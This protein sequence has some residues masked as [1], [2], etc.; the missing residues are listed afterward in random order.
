MDIISEEMKSYMQGKNIL[1]ASGYI[2]IRV[3]GELLASSWGIK[4]GSPFSHPLN[5]I[6][7]LNK[8]E[9]NKECL[10][11]FLK[12]L[13][14]ESVYY[15]EK[16]YDFIFDEDIIYKAIK[17]DKKN[18]VIDSCLYLY[19][20]YSRVERFFDTITIQ[21]LHRD[22]S[23]WGGGRDDKFTVNSSDEE[24]IVEYLYNLINN[25]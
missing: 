23:A 18:K 16:G 4:E 10:K 3:N 8:K 17:E 5:N 9:C 21:K 22:G 2:Y 15:E 20:V 11:S 14:E 12:C 24:E 25:S 6:K 7:R 19:V 1:A 13:F